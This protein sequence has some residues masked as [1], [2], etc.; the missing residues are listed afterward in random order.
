M[1]RQQGFRKHG[2]TYNRP[3]L[4]VQASKRTRNARHGAYVV[5]L[6]QRLGIAIE[7]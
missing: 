7:P 3:T 2:R 1:L 5:G 4:K 6:A